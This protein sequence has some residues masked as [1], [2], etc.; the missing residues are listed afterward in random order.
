MLKKIFIQLIVLAMF[1]AFIPFGNFASVA[2]KESPKTNTKG[3]EKTEVVGERTQTSKTFNNSD[4]TYTTE[5]YET[6]I[7]FKDNKGNWKDIDNDLQKKKNNGKGQF[8]NKANNFAVTFDEKIEEETNNVQVADNQYNLNI[9][10]KEMEQKGEIIPAKEVIGVAT[11]NQIQYQ[12]VFDNISTTYS[13]GENFV[14]EDIIINK[15]PEKGIPQTFSY[16]LSLESLTYEQIN[17]QIHLKDAK[18]GELVYVIE[19][20]FMYDAYKPAG[21]QSIDGT[22]SI[23]EEAKSYNISLKTRKENNTLWIDL[24][25][26][27]A[28]LQDTKRQ[29]PIVIDPTIVRIQG[30]SKMVDTTIR[31]KFPTQTEGND[32]ERS[33]EF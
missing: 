22:I 7:H 3:N 24:T 4:G 28:W 9:G 2:A 33:L 32:T 31:K 12:N 17:N 30:N 29:Y 11:D 6:P 26:D 1:I 19:A 23:P 27:T 13:V 25:P 5:I 10:L 14:K 21:F 18:T 16:Q 15:K 8:E 20:P